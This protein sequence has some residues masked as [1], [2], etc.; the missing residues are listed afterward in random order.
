MIATKCDFFCF[1]YLKGDFYLN[2]NNTVLEDEESQDLAINQAKE[3][4]K[5]AMDK[6]EN[7]SKQL[8]QVKVDAQSAAREAEEL[9]KQFQE[10]VKAKIEVQDDMANGNESK[11]VTL[12]KYTESRLM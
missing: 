7:L 10:E 2:L 3:A 9:I 5:K 6:S 11:K 8:Q 1:R 12:I 4:A